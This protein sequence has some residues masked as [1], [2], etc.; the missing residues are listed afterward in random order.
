MYSNET[1]K[2]IKKHRH[3][4]LLEQVDRENK[5]L[6][7]RG[8]NMETITVKKVCGL[9]EHLDDDGWCPILGAVLLKDKKYN[10]EKFE[11]KKYLVYVSLR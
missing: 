1:H 5:I 8:V 11:L 4:Q 2:L 7:Y 6:E 9:C 3:N 10:Y